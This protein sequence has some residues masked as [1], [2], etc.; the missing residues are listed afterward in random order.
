MGVERAIEIT[1]RKQK[2]SEQYW[3]TKHKSTKFKIG[4]T[5]M[6]FTPHINRTNSKKHKLPWSGPF[7]INEI[8]KLQ[9]RYHIN[10]LRHYIERE[11]LPSLDEVEKPFHQLQELTKTQKKELRISELIGKRISVWWT[12]GYT[13]G[14]PGYFDG[15]IDSYNDQE[16]TFKIIYD[17]GQRVWE[18]LFKSKK[19]AAQAKNQNL[20][21]RK[22]PSLNR[23]RM[24]GIRIRLRIGWILMRIAL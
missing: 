4:D 12:S 22:K 1:R 8:E 24:Q 18:R 14:K 23:K 3:A 15:Y 9:D 7:I 16:K 11:K 17:D 20:N 13:G 10:R 2:Y 5:V 6:L 19:G 21:P